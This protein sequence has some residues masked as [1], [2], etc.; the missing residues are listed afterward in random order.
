MFGY[1]FIIFVI[2]F[3]MIFAEKIYLVIKFLKNIPDCSRVRGTGESF[4]TKNSVGFC[5]GCVGFCGGLRRF[6]R[7]FYL[8]AAPCCIK[9]LKNIFDYTIFEKIYLFRKFLKS[10]HFS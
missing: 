4:F 1:F 10:R 9:F 8:Y 7:G 2:N 6:L 3:V 5:V